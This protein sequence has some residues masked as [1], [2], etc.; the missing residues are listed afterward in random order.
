YRG[1]RYIN[2]FFLWWGVYFFYNRVIYIVLFVFFVYYHTRYLLVMFPLWGG[3]VVLGPGVQVRER[4]GAGGGFS[5][6]TTIGIMFGQNM[7]PDSDLVF[8]DLYRI[9]SV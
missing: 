8:S 2:R 5:S 4:G 6:I 7:H 9:T 1:T 3:G